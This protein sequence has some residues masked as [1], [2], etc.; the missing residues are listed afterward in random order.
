MI[1]SYNG[2]GFFCRRTTS[3]EQDAVRAEAAAVDHRFV[4]N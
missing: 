4:V 3:I 1:T 2:Q